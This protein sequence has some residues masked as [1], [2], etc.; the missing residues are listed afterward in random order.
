MTLFNKE[1]TVLFHKELAHASLLACKIDNEIFYKELLFINLN[2]VPPNFEER[3]LIPY[4]TVGL[5]K[6]VEQFRKELESPEK[7]KEI[8]EKRNKLVQ[9]PNG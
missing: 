2:V 6:G 5:L 8:K 7:L 3:I 4:L 9:V 1:G